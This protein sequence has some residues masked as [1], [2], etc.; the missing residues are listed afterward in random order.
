MRTALTDM[1][2]PGVRL[3]G[4]GTHRLR[5]IPEPTALYQV[6]A[7]GLPTSFGPIRTTT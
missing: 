2:P 5:G 7:E 6:L 3:R 4:L 1:M